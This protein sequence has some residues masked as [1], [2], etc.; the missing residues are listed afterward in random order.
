MDN[1]QEKSYVRF[2]FPFHALSDQMKRVNQNLI[3]ENLGSVYSFF[4]SHGM[5]HLDA[6]AVKRFQ[7]C[8]TIIKIPNVTDVLSYIVNL[9][10]S[11]S[12]SNIEHQKRPD[13]GL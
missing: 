2:T 3:I 9:F 6:K 5:L 12:K 10:L 11:I 8:V 4:F 13:S 7:G 1:I